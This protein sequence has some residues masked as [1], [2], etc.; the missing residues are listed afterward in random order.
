MKVVNFSKIFR[1]LNQSSKYLN[2]K[3]EKL[4]D[5]ILNKEVIN[6][7]IFVISILVYPIIDIIRIFSLRLIKKKSP[8]I[9]D[10]NH[11]HHNLIKTFKKKIP[12][13]VFRILIKLILFQFKDVTKNFSRILAYYKFKKKFLRRD[14]RVV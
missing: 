5:E 3:Y 11:I 1:V 2:Y 10:N 4:Y 7:I 6:K 13:L 14:G 8:F 12:K 9:A